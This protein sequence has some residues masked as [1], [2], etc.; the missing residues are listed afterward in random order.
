M[1]GSPLIKEEKKVA[2]VPA[3]PEPHR[4]PQ[5]VCSPGQRE[6]GPS[7]QLSLLLGLCFAPGPWQSITVNNKVLLYNLKEPMPLKTISFPLG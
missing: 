7:T 4:L 5:A 2:A 6:A 3:T 1:Y